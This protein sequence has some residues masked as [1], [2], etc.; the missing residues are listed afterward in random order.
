MAGQGRGI[1]LSEEDLVSLIVAA[2]RKL[3]AANL[4][5]NQLSLQAARG[6]LSGRKVAGEAALAEALDAARRLLDRAAADLS[7]IADMRHQAPPL[8]QANDDLPD[9]G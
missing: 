6:N 3:D 8:S 1:I 9:N 2:H 4:V 5:L 7:E